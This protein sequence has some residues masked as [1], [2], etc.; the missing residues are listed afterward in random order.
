M[1][2]ILGISEPVSILSPILSVLL[3]VSIVPVLFASETL[4]VTELNSRRLR[5]HLDK[6]GWEV[7]KS[8]K[9]K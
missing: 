9:A 4:P 6:V 5:E 2:L 7:V 1:P 8:K 3:F